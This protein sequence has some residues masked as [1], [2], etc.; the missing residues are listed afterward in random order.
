MPTL[1]QT[2]QTAL[3]LSRAGQLPQAEALYRQVLQHNI[4]PAEAAGIWNNLANVL[5]RMGRLQEAATAYRQAIALAPGYALAH[6]NLA[7][8][9]LDLRD[10]QQAIAACR[11][12]LALQPNSPQVHNTLGTACRDLGRLD[13]AIAAY[14]Q[15]IALSPQYAEAHSSLGVV[16]RDAGFAE[17]AIAA[18]RQAIALKPDYAEAHNNLAVALREHGTLDEAVAACRRALALNPDYAQAHSTLAVLLKDRG[19]LDAA[20]AAYDRTLALNPHFASADSGR[21]YT[22]YFHPA[23]DAHAICREHQL[24][25]Q[26]HAAPLAAR[27]QPHANDRSPDRRLRI[28]YVSPDFRD[29]VVSRFL[30]PLLESHDHQNVEVFCYSSVARPDEVTARFQRAADH[31]R[32]ATRLND[33]ELATCIRMDR[34]D[35]LIDLTMHMAGGRLLAFAR[36]PAP[37]QATYLAYCGTTGLAAMDYR[38]SD[39]YFDPPGGDESCYSE[40]TIRLQ[41]YWCYQSSPHA[42]EVSEL[43]ALRSGHVTFGCLNNFAKVSAGALATWAALLTLVPGSRLILHCRAGSHRVQVMQ[44]L[45]AGGVDAQRIEL[46]DYLPTAEYFALHR[47]IDIALDPFPYG[48]GTTSCDALWMGVPLVTLAGPTAVGRGGVSI[49]SHLGLTEWIA[50]TPA[51]YVEKA[52][53]LA[54]DLPRLS[55]LRATL[56]QRMAASRLMDAPLFARDMEAANRAMWMEYVSTASSV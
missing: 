3:A 24:W 52:R 34:I 29:H 21:I 14:R 30:L 6:A 53:A 25:N 56:R 18:T 16:L 17:E 35:I 15:A 10:P 7:I 44:A 2:L 49:L 48:G 26:R 36:K 28:G 20:L 5:R 42:A 45:A 19:E 22:L 50:H 39:P 8:A 37:V 11:A 46:V 47:R 41:S 31:W 27:L 51:G 32:D 43:P 9:L 4:H 23:Y 12:A 40:K 33:E 13:D 55:G 1:P 54:G 38:L